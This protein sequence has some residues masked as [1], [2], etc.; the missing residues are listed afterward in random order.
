MGDPFEKWLEDADPAHPPEQSDDALPGDA[1][2]EEREYFEEHS[3]SDVEADEADLID[4][5]R[6]VPD[7][8]DG[9]HRWDV[10]LLGPP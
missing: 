9:D 10:T 8:E 5:V 6:E 3:A 1:D 2:V 4:Q 7:D